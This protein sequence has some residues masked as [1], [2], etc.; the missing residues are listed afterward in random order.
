MKELRA[1]S[2]VFLFLVL[3]GPLVVMA[4]GD[5]RSGRHLRQALQAWERRDLQ[6]AAAAAARVLRGDPSNGEALMLMADICREQNARNEE[7]I[8]LRRVADAGAGGNLL[9]FRLGEALFLTASYGEALEKLTHFLASQPRGTLLTRATT[10]YQHAAFAASAIRNPVPFNPVD[11]GTGVNSPLD[12]YWPSL[13]V[14]GNTLI[15]TRRVPVTGATTHW[16][17]DFFMSRF[18]KKQWGEAVPLAELNTLANE[19]A[20]SLSADGKL[21]FFTL[22]NHPGGFGS[23]DLWFS[24]FENGQWTPPRNAGEA[25]NTAGWEGQPS[26]SAFGDQL[27]FSSERSGG[28]GKKDLWVVPLKGWREDGIPLWGGVVNAGDSINTQGD[29]ISPFLHPGGRDLFFASDHWPGFGGYDLFHAVLLPGEIWSSPENLG[30]PVN[31][32]GNE[33]GLV[34]DRSGVHAWFATGREQ[35]AH[36]DICSFELPEALRPSPVSYIR[37]KVVNDATALPVAASVNIRASSPSAF[38]AVTIP[39]DE[40]GIFLAALPTEVELVFTVE[41]PGFL[42]YSERFAIPET[43]GIPDPVL[44]EIRLKPARPGTSMDL[45]QIFFAL[46][47][48]EILPPSEPELLVLL[49]FLREN[50]TLRVEIGGHTDSTGGADFNRELSLKRAA[51]VRDYLVAKGIDPGR[52]TSQ[53]YGMDHPLATNDTEEG[54]SLNRRTTISVIQ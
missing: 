17:E 34:T 24:K 19:G 6:G 7:L 52:V 51:S 27:F 42:F 25:V 21:L 48:Y 1:I 54:R 49:R 39:A 12:E 53:G 15:F 18:D 10:L 41:H 4:Q 38:P 20:P 23:C 28:K 30:A 47:E 11:P 36:M 37:G 43:K 14:D 5:G 26:L 2:V 31:S 33:Q 40:E 29:E 35:G 32:P 9:D 46:N 22:C 50:P 16:Q 8:Y 45:Y 3:M 44:R 13:T